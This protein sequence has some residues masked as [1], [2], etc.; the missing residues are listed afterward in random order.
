MRERVLREFVAAVQADGYRKARVN[1]VCK[2][3]GISARTFYL[4]FDSKEQCYLVAFERLSDY[5]TRRAAQAFNTG[6]CRPWEERMRAA[7][8]AIANEIVEHPAVAVLL[9][10]CPKIDGGDA[11][12]AQFVKKAEQFYVTDEVLYAMLSTTSSASASII[13]SMW[14]EPIMRCVRAGNV[15]LITE[16]VPLIAPSMSRVLF[17]QERADHLR[18]RPVA[19]MPLHGDARSPLPSSSDNRL[20]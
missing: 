11:A 4:C 16:M 12:M 13:S 19:T 7:L 6:R 8:D 2:S 17:G 18:P 1:D 5:L 9:S 15:G 20:S 10:E 14:A 3:A